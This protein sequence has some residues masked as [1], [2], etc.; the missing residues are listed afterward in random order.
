MHVSPL[1]A[2]WSPGPPEMLVVLFVALL[3]YGGKLPEVAR[4]W[5]KSFAEFRR[6]LTGIQ[7]DI[8]DAIYSEPERLEYRDDPYQ[9]KNYDQPLSEAT[10]QSGSE[11]LDEAAGDLAHDSAVDSSGEQSPPMSE[12]PSD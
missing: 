3:L 7:H 1:V 12:L 2:F 9:M 6:N 4:S 10:D 8:N 11:P 5:G